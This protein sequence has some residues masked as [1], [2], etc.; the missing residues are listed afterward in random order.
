MSGIWLA[1]FVVLCL[2]VIALALLTLSLL[3]L[4]G[5][6]HQRMGPAGAL[7]TES[8]P[9]LRDSLPDLLVAEGFVDD[10]LFRF[11]KTKDTLLIAISPSCPACEELLPS[12]VP[13]HE[14]GRKRLEIIVVSS[15]SEPEGNLRLSQK[16]ARAG[17]AYLASP[18]LSTALKIGPTP[19][20]IWLDEDGVVR[21]KGLVNH[22]EHLESLQN[23]RAA[24]LAS[25]EEHL[26]AVA[27]EHG[28]PMDGGIK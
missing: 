4:V 9:T 18:K 23:A 21:A 7:V 22:T 20:G 3:R 24:G 13:F 26:S 27:H 16:V 28:T 14:R 6:L 2:V 17:I 25:H 19:F 11:P 8:G 12:L 5:Q 10:A 1:S 15:S